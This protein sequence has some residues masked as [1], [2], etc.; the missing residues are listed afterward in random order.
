MNPEEVNNKQLNQFVTDRITEKLKN[1]PPNLKQR[2]IAKIFIIFRLIWDMYNAKIHQQDILDLIHLIEK[3]DS[4][5][6][7]R[8]Q[9]PLT[10]S[11]QAADN[12]WGDSQQNTDIYIYVDGSYDPARATAGTGIVLLNNY[13]SMISTEMLQ[14]FKLKGG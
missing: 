13:R 11:E 6:E 8:T 4:Y 3:A 12:A 14:V 5:I 10:N 9:N 2:Y 7:P 1:L